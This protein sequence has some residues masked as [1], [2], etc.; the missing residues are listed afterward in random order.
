[1]NDN[2]GQRLLTLLGRQLVTAFEEAA[3]AVAADLAALPADPRFAGTP[4]DQRVL[5][6][7][8]PDHPVLALL[9]EL[10]ADAAPAHVGLHGWRAAPNDGAPP[11]LAYVATSGAGAIAMITVVPA[12]G[13]QLVLRAAG[14]AGGQLISVP[15]L[16]D[17]MLTIS[18]SSSDEVEIVF[19]PDQP[20][21]VNRL[22]AGT[23]IDLELARFSAGDRLGPEGGPSVV[24]GSVSL[25]GFIGAAPDGSFQRGG[26]LVLKG[27]QVQLTPDY[28]KGLL[29]VDLSFPLDLDLAM[30]AAAGIALGGSPSLTARLTGS[31]DRWLDLV[32]G[33]ADGDSPS[34]QVSFR[35]SLAVSLPGAPVELRVDGLGFGLPLSLDVGTPLLPDP[36]ALLPAVPDGAGVSVD[37]PVV[38]GSGMLLKI[39]DDLAGALTVKIPP[40]TASAFG[41][42]A[43]KSERGPLSFLVIMGATFPPPGVQIGFGFA[44]T[45]MGGVVGINRRIDRDAMMR[46]VSD[47]TAAQL[48]FPS[49]PV[50]AGRSA[51]EALP[52]IFPAAAGSVVAGPMFQIGWGGRIVALSAAVL[53]ESSRQVRITILGKLVLAVPDP[54][55][56]LIFLQ[57]TFA[58]FIDPA[59]PSVLFIASLTGSHIVGVALTGDLLLLTRGGS[60]PTFVISAGGFHPAFR[61]P[62]GVPA[63]RR[64]AMDLCPVSW[65]SMRCES[66]FALTSNTLQFGLRLELSAEVAGCGLRGYFAFDALV[67]YSPFRFIADV[68]GGIALRAFGETLMGISLAFHLE[69]PAPYLARGRGSIDLFFFEVSF[70]FELGWG[71]P[72]PA[73]AAGN[74]G[75]DL[76][77]ALV[78]PAAWR[79]RASAPAGLVLT[80][81]AQKSLSA[82]T[83][84][85]PYGTVT[86]RQEVVPLAIEL[87]RY[88]G[89]PCQPQRWDLI[90]G[91]FGP[92]EAA[93]HTNEVRAQFAPGQFVPSK[94]DD[95][96]LTAAAF[97]PLRAGVE[98]YPAP[99][100]GAESRAAGLVWEESVVARDI[101]RPIPW[102]LGIVLELGSVEQILTTEYETWWAPPDDVVQVEPVPPAAGAWAWSMSAT[103]VS[104][105]STFEVAQVSDLTVLAVEAWEL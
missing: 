29:P 85:D 7:I 47:G 49:D 55:A 12:E 28:L 10:S 51:I 16:G 20:P 5:Q 40:M 35:T 36:A 45:G 13:P 42:L 3:N 48:L 101:P 78:A 93:H 88:G 95:E 46:A 86:V 34:L 23:R 52:R 59:E 60:D 17:L 102:A 70:D 26:H 63:L 39:G 38:G 25:G 57:A 27:G 30:T 96:A 105:A 89:V 71:S 65:I 90:G 56:P 8:A 21:T 4:Y 68:S 33:V 66:Y 104:G 92:G 50:G 98:L 19:H 84:V 103:D 67:Q 100:A 24:F 58:G 99:A 76:R 61:R 97:L 53:V 64:L 80:D 43:P 14:L 91:E 15:V 77:A 32:L 75:A 87:L 18:G 69:G 9:T 6:Q 94:S 62:R 83:I 82:A 37:L 1:M 81:A 72:A 54:E 11:G 74:V 31:G 79:S 73:V 22:A 44:I 2:P 41:L